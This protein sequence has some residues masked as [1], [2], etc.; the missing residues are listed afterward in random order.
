VTSL[1]TL[2]CAAPL[3]TC[4]YNDAA[5]LITCIYNDA[6]PLITCI[7][8]DAAPL[9]FPAAPCKRGSNGLYIT[10]TVSIMSSINLVLN[11]SIQTRRLEIETSLNKY[12]RFFILRIKLSRFHLHRERNGQKLTVP[13]VFCSFK[14]ITL[15][16]VFY[17]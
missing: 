16:V 5:P 11:L 17:A 15:S 2:T 14:F 1:R 9:R 8:N 7:Y 13:T 12:L 6:A 4:I 3:I 10:T